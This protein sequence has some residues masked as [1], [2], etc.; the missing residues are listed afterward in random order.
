[1]NR[2][3]VRLIRE[4]EVL[5]HYCHRLFD[6][7]GGGRFL[8][9]SCGNRPDVREVVESFD[10]TWVGVDH[11]EHPRV[12]KANAHALP[13][14]DSRF[15]V[16]YASAAFE[17]YRDPWCVA[18]EV[19]RIL[20]PGGYFCGLIA[21]IQPW[22]GA[23]YYHFSHL[24]VAEMLHRI[25]FEVLDIHAGD[26]DGAT[27]LI[28]LLFHYWNLGRVL[29][30]YGRLLYVVRRHLFPLLIRCAL[31]GKRERLAKELAVLK[32]D[33]LR[34]AASVIFLS[35]KTGGFG[36]GAIQA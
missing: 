11:I 34:F 33:D 16:V 1:M 24:G 9:L 23:S 8:D 28:R 26:V 31:H 22:H 15:D 25:D 20:K 32:D 2:R 18:H 12:I 21:F 36:G 4:N 29:S 10:Y 17:H 7:R 35:R 6:R 30:L 19:R 14:R 13:F 5:R 27:Y 3:T